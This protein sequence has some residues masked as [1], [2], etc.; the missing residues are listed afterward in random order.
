M[1]GVYQY[2]RDNNG[3]V[4]DRIEVVGTCDAK[5]ADGEATERRTDDPREIELH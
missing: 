1:P 5:Y 4:A 2:Q 3:N